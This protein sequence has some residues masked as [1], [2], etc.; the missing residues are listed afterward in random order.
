MR[1][2]LKIKMLSAIFFDSFQAM[3][4]SLKEVPFVETKNRKKIP[5]ILQVATKLLYI[6]Y[7]PY[8]PLRKM[9]RGLYGNTLI[10]R[11][12]PATLSTISATASPTCQ[13][14][15]WLAE[16]SYETK[17]KVTT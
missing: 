4:D 2:I 14:L 8:N 13:L 5:T 15:F 3:R 12:L 6:K 9:R 7:F 11:C 1:N 16:Q 10:L 17:V